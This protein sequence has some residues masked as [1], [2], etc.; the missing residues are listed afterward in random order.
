MNLTLGTPGQ[1]VSVTLDTGSSDLWVN[2]ANA[3]VCPCDYGSYSP[4]DSSTYEFVNDDFYIQYVDNSEAAGDYVNDTLQFANVTLTNFQFA[5][6]Y[7]G[8]SDGT[9]D[10][11]YCLPPI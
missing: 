5:V 11:S 3:S 6:A 7:D 4:S 9:S 2:A 8:D 1:A 10:H